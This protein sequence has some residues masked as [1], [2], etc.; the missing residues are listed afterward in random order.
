MI[1]AELQA[2]SWHK[3]NKNLSQMTLA[4]YFQSMS[5]N[6]FKSNIKY[7]EKAGFDE[8][9]LW[10]AEWWYFMKENKNYNGYWNEA[11]KIWQ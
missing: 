2:E 10:G 3:E 6:Q 11:K 8:I 1:V 7:A 4:E 9:Y 5:L